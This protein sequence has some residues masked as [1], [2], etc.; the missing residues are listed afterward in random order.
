[1]ALTRRRG[2]TPRSASVPTG[3]ALRSP[4]ARLS[5]REPRRRDM[6]DQAS[7]G[8][9]ASQT[10]AGA[11]PSEGE[12]PSTRS[13]ER[14]KPAPDLDAERLGDDFVEGGMELSPTG[15]VFP[16]L[17]LP[18]QRL[19]ARLLGECWPHGE[20]PRALFL[21][22]DGTLR[23]FEARPEQ[24]VPTEEII[25]LLEAIDAREDLEPHIISGR[26]ARFLE[27]CFQ[28]LTRFTLIAE[29]GYQIR[30]P[31]VEGWHLWDH[32]GV[33]SHEE[34]K[35]VMRDTILDIVKLLPGSHLEEKTSSLVWH[36]RE[37][38]DAAQAEAMADHGVEI[39]SSLKESRNIHDVK[40]SHGHKIV[41]V[42]YRKV[43]KGLVMRKLCEEKALFG[44]PYL[45]VLV[46]GDDV[47]D[48]S[49]FDL[50]PQD[51]LTIKVG[52]G[53]TLAR[54]RVENPLELRQFLWKTVVGRQYS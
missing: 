44:K 2:T 24:A 27:E 38:V 15:E 4:P 3:F 12:S 29:H 10:E 54:F 30:R 35:V 41:E 47:S 45:G 11:R 46:A 34:W 50:A 22:Y 21:D 42:S 48:E 36:Y 7:P 26:D 37:V 52:E 39:L 20:G 49:M 31:G 19:D 23:E 32:S 43:R 8:T 40:I 1:M 16:P 53:Q 51:T 9:Q 13:R 28:R 6:R 5:S 17:E 18:T 25:A 33:D 14:S